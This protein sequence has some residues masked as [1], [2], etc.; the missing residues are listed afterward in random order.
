MITFSPDGKRIAWQ[1]FSS[2]ESRYYRRSVELWLANV[3]GSDP[4]KVIAVRG[5]GIVGWFPN[6]NRWLVLGS[7]FPQE[8]YSLTV[9]DLDSANGLEIAR[10]P[11]LGGA[12]I[13]PRGGDWVVFQVTASGD[14]QRDGLWVVGTDGRGMRRLDVYGSYQWRSEGRLAIV[15]LEVSTQSDLESHRLV[16]VEAVSGAVRQL[17]DP[18]QLSFRIANGDWSMAPDGDKFVY[19]SAE[20]HNL[21]VIELP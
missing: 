15:P 8:S 18:T 1:V 21:W 16:E 19:V 12:S 11:R 4:R 7:N 13:S 6:S 10:A 2:Q 20:D 5:G 9:F 14:A 17:T 3:D